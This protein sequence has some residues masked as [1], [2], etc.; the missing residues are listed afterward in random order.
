M[1]SLNYARGRGPEGGFRTHSRS[2]FKLQVNRLKVHSAVGIV[3]KHAPFPN[4]IPLAIVVLLS[5]MIILSE[6]TLPRNML[7]LSETILLLES[8]PQ[9]CHHEGVLPS[10]HSRDSSIC[11]FPKCDRACHFCMNF[12]GL[13]SW[14]S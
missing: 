6:T 7:L 4:A 14:K 2:D 13:A 3:F 1:K 8:I 11:R 5:E 12:P 10:G 9:S